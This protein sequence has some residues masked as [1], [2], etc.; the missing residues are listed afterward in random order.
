MFIPVNKS[1]NVSAQV[2]ELVF[3]GD[4]DKI[5]NRLIDTEVCDITHFG[6]NY[7]LQKN[8]NVRFCLRF[9]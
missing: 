5:S 2:Y 8:I 9:T 1:Y 3:E 7:Y 4:T 6:R